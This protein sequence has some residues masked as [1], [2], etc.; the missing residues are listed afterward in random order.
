MYAV[1]IVASGTVSTC[2]RTRVRLHRGVAIPATTS[3]L[4]GC[5]AAGICMDARPGRLVH[6]ARLLACLGIRNVTIAEPRYFQNL[7]NFAQ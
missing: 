2:S 3:I 5:V 7:E 6:L 1:R 4:D